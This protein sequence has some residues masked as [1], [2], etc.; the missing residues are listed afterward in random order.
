MNSPSSTYSSSSKGTVLVVDDE[1]LILKTLERLLKPHYQV[2][3]HDNAKSSLDIVRKQKIHVVLS[4]Q[5]MPNMTG[6]EFLSKVK[7]LSPNSVRLLLTGYSDS[8]A[9]NKAINDSEVFR[10]I[11]KPWK[12]DELLKIVAQSVDIAKTADSVNQENK[13]EISEANE[14]ELQSEMQEKMTQTVIMNTLLTH[15]H[16]LVLDSNMELQKTVESIIDQRAKVHFTKSIDE[17]LQCLEEIP[18]NVVLI[19][20][21]MDY[22]REIAFIKT[23]KALCPSILVLVLADEP[24]S[25]QMIELINEGQVYRY[26][27]KPIR[28]GLLKMYLLS[29]LRYSESL[30]QNPQIAK[31]HV[32]NEIAEP[33]QKAIAQNFMTRIRSFGRFLTA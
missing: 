33:E 8:K 14:A 27:S 32:V 9:I 19:S 18:Q 25:E 5:R 4:D 20:L 3:T 21:S 6:V 11:N 17:A 23:L 28:L 16:L 13:P 30:Q 22:R 24:D 26:T 10:F 1:P 12:N 15:S 2:I 29:S 7:K 31:R